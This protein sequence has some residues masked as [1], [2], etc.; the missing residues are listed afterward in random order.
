MG[1]ESNPSKKTNGPGIDRRTFLR[2][3]GVAGALVAAGKLAEVADRKPNEPLEMIPE[4]RGEIFSSHSDLPPEY[5]E[6]ILAWMHDTMFKD[7]R[8]VAQ[9]NEFVADI[10]EGKDVTFPGTV[11]F[12][13]EDSLPTALPGGNE[14]LQFALNTNFSFRDDTG[15][16]RL[17]DGEVVVRCDTWVSG[18]VD[19][20]RYTENG[21]YLGKFSS[22]MIVTFI[23]N[24]STGE[25]RRFPKG[26]PAKDLSRLF[27]NES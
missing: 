17:D 19:S 18:G 25:V 11:S 10:R 7:P 15:P 21:I 27:T 1:M 9:M 20:R 14:K 6:K 3:I 22:I 2:G 23:Y 8:V 26:N 4:D 12:S 13:Q 16:V 5:R 24:T